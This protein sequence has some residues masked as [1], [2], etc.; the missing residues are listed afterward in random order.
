MLP[1]T[2]SGTQF[3]DLM[4]KM[5]FIEAMK[6][7]DIREALAEYAHDSW[8]GWMR[9]LFRKSE[10]V[11]DRGACIPEEL[12]ERW[13]RQMDTKYQDLPEKE[14]ESDRNEADKIIA[15]LQK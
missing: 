9:Y 10:L 7:M 12:V 2:T 14:K 3:E 6:T 11:P 1:S 5:G 4:K 8:A 15:L 13:I